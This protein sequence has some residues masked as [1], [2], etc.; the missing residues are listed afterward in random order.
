VRQLEQLERH[1]FQ[2][3]RIDDEQRLGDD[4]RCRLDVRGTRL[5]T[6]GIGAQA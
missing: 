2:H 1:E 6:V 4:L 5:R 3:I